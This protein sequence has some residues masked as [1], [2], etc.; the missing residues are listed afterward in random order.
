MNYGDKHTED[1]L[2]LRLGRLYGIE[3]GLDCGP[4]IIMSQYKA[5]GEWVIPKIMHDGREVYC[6]FEYEADFLYITKG[7]YLYEVEIKLS[8][9]DFRA[10]Q[11][12][13]L[14]HNFPDVRGFYYCMPM[15]L[16]AKHKEE[17]LHVCKEKGAGLIVENK[18]FKVIKKAPQR[19]SVEPLTD[20]RY[21]HY[22]RL[23]AKKWV[24]RRE[25][26]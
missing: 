12:K 4:N 8:I 7:R 26:D 9:A 6:S 11:Q 21:L 18:E 20:S 19:K 15:E 1:S 3:R 23:F 17:V 10:D 2:C 24:R 13:T 5:D 14:Y 25:G 22:I 16:Y